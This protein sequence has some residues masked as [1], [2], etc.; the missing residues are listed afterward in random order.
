[1]I[2]LRSLEV[3]ADVRTFDKFSAA[4]WVLHFKNTGQADTPIIENVQP[5]TWTLPVTAPQPVLHWAQGSNASGDDFMP[6][7]TAALVRT[8]RPN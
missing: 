8:N 7:Q 6:A 5:L 1:M 3:V 2:P 4:D